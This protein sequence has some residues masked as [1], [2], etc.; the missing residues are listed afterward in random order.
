MGGRVILPGLTDAHIHLQEYALSLQVVDCEVESRQEILQRVAERA[1]ETPPG[2]WVRGH[3]WNQNTWGGEWPTAADLDAVSPQNPVYLTAKSLHAAW[4]NS[5]AL[6]LAGISASTPDP[7]NG[8]IQR[9]AR[10]HPTGIVFEE[11][12]KLV[13]AAI[14]EP[15]PEALAKTFQQLIPKLWSMGLTGVHDFDKRTC[16]MALQSLTSDVAI[17]FACG[18]IHSA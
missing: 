1:R 2:E 10:G 9:D 14:P 5:A 6:K 18:E 17:T 11:A 15:T 8:R 13:E 7:V 3:G 16:F 12:V 4:V